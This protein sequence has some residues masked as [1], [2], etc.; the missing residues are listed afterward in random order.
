MQQ[1]LPVEHNKTRAP[2][3]LL[4]ALVMA[5]LVFL[6][7]PV[8]QHLGNPR[9]DLIEFREAITITPPAPMVLPPTPE[10]IQP[11]DP[12]PTP[13]FK[14]QLQDF[15]LSRL[16]LSLNPGISGALRIGSAGNSFMTEVDALSEIQQLFT[17]ADLESAP[18]IINNPSIVYPRELIR[19]GIREGRVLV[20]IEI[21]TKGRARVLEIISATEPRLIPAAKEV[22][23]KARFTAPK[24]GGVPQKVHGEWPIILRAP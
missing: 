18:R 12:E 23:R 11:K 6:A 14:Q 7:I 15:S 9:S 13:E 19:S 2:L 4:G 5:L 22:I 17:F 24:V 8:T 1:I 16:E 21:D 20:R 3:A 10:Q